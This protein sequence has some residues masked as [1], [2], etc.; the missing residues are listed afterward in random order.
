MVTQTYINSRHNGG[1]IQPLKIITS[2]TFLLKMSSTII[3][4]IKLKSI[5]LSSNKAN[6]TY[7]SHPTWLW[8]SYEL[9][10]GYQSWLFIFLHLAVFTNS[11]S[12]GSKSTTFTLKITRRDFPKPTKILSPKH[13]LSKYFKP[14]NNGDFTYNRESSS[15]IASLETFGFTSQT[16]LNESIKDVVFGC[17]NYQKAP[18]KSSATGMNRSPLSF[19]GQMRLKLRHRFSY[20]LPPF[21]SSVQTTTFLRFASDVKGEDLRK[22]SLLTTLITTIEWL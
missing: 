18:L 12:V 15:S 16:R 11:H 22:I 8:E 14:S 17:S 6:I 3:N 21:D 13:T 5:S 20:C 2:H 9:K 1:L 10:H 19:I 4:P 7:I